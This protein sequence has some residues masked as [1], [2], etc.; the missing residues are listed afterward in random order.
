MHISRVQAPES[1]SFQTTPVPL[2]QP[3]A[4]VVD[5]SQGVVLSTTNATTANDLTTEQAFTVRRWLQDEVRR[6][7]ALRCKYSLASSSH[8]SFWVL[9][10]WTLLVYHFSYSRGARRGSHCRIDIP[11]H[12]SGHLASAVGS[13]VFVLDPSDLE[14]RNARK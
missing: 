1:G 6:Y 10:D 4:P 2:A 12:I 13:T 5:G 3:V 8:N 14:K 7:P 11:R 9:K